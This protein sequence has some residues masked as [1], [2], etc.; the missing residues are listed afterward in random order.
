MV[1]SGMCPGVGLLDHTVDLFL[2]FL[3]NRHTVLHS[4]YTN[5]R[6]HQQ[7]RRVSFSPHPKGD[8]FELSD[9]RE[10]KQ[11]GSHR[12]GFYFSETQFSYAQCMNII[13]IMA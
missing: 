12:P 9:V 7:C 6:S 10:A 13:H 5:L 8:H 2:V 1:F 4:G 3:R 11:G